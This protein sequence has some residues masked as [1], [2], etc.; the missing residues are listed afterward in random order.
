MKNLFKAH[1]TYGNNVTVNQLNATCFECKIVKSCLSF[2]A[3]DSEYT[4]PT[5]CISCLIKFDSGMI[6]ASSWENN[7]VEGL[8]GEVK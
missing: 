4:S 6:S 1:G 8:E 7:N 5:F 3:S 2:D